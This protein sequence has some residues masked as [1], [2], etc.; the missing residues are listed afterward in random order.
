MVRK[1]QR[2]LFYL[3]ILLIPVLTSCKSTRIDTQGIK[4]QVYWTEGNLMPQIS[5][6]GQTGNQPPKEGVKRVIKIHELTHINEARLGDYLF[7]EI[8]TPLVST[9]ETDNMGNFEIE[10][11]T[12]KYS[13]FTVEE[14]GYF[15]NVFDLDSYIFPVEVEENSWTQVE[16]LIDYEAAY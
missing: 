6:N 7:G 10:L 2:V 11:P 14:K 15:A 13:L 1:I 12:G 5:E 8:E 9:K 4:G 16:I 3:G